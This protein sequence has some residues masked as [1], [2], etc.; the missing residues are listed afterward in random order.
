MQPTRNDFS[1]CIAAP[2][3]LTDD[4]PL[5][6]EWF[7][8]W[9]AYHRELGVSHV[10]VYSAGQQPEPDLTR[11]VGITFDWLKLPWLGAFDTWNQGQMWAMHDCLFRARALEHRWT[12]FLDMDEVVRLP[13]QFTLHSLAAKL[14]SDG[15]VGAS[16]GS[17]PYLH[18][19]C[20]PGTA[21]D[22]TMTQKLSYRTL[23]PE[24][25]QWEGHPHVQASRCP[26][27]QGR[28]KFMIRPQATHKLH[29]HYPVV[30]AELYA[31]LDSND[32]F[33]VKHARGAPW[34]RGMTCNGAGCQL[35][36]DGALL[37]P[38]SALRCDNCASPY[39]EWSLAN[40]R[41]VMDDED[42]LL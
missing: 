30:E 13:P 36:E 12:L 21:A 8:A 6:A 39:G 19:Y 29:I 23:E 9:T 22:A 40:S 42:S 27:W 14:E 10:F 3:Q 41:W 2:L 31:D 28:R 24:C 38:P 5:N 16:F 11:D 25:E 18:G 26:T 17:V 15:K 20:R 35:Q 37:C 34:G 32:G 7:A 1:V 33:W 4:G